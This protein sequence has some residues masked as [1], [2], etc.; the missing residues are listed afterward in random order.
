MATWIFQGDPQR[1]RVT[2]YL[3][4]TRDIRW[5][6]KQE[7]Y[8]SEMRIGDRAF[9]WRARG[10][11]K[12]PPGIIASGHLTSVPTIEA[13]DPLAVPLWIDGEN[14]GQALRVRIHVDKVAD[15]H[16]LLNR[17]TLKADPLL[18]NL[19]IVT[20]AQQTNFPVASE[21]VPRL[22]QLW[23]AT[24]TA[25]TEDETL[26]ALWAYT[27][28][29]GKHSQS[30]DESAVSEVAL[31]TG[32]GVAAV[33]SKTRSFLGLDPRDSRTGLPTSSKLDRQVWDTYFDAN[34]GTIDHGRLER[35]YS[36]VWRDIPPPDLSD[37]VAPVVLPPAGLSNE[38]NR[39]QRVQGYE[40][41]ARVRK[42]V[43]DHA[44][45]LAMEHYQALGFDVQD[46]SRHE[47]YDLRCTK[48]G[49]EVRVEVK[50]TRGQGATVEVTVAEVKNARGTEWRTDLFVVRAIEVSV[51][52]SI[53]GVGGQVH[54]I[55][56]WRAPDEALSPTRYKCLVA[57]SGDA[58]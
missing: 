10:K 2:E 15:G 49:S 34:S 12:S 16:G 11:S 5:T 40:P 19:S 8:A 50:G 46:T 38:Y 24:G 9:I 27:R 42:A 18:R 6:V 17:H 56:G 7:K 26:A 25:W 37:S 4:L 14:T 39:S 23:A 28:S 20:F 44:M 35:E 52:P 31:M 1:F 13:E 55:E 45:K 30:D 43:E 21:L 29:G 33:V 3:E 47:S 22:E 53:E 58:L 57:T 48:L 41:D 32:R 51:G 54:V 36:R